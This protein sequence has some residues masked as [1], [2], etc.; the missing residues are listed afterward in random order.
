MTQAALDLLYPED[1][2]TAP[3]RVHHPT[4]RH[5]RPR[6]RPQPGQVPW[7]ATATVPARVLVAEDDTEMRRLLVDA[8]AHAGYQ[9][10]EVA[11]GRQLLAC[12]ADPHHRD[13]CPEPDLVVSDIRMPGHSGLDVLAAL[14]QHDWA[15]P[16]LIITAFGSPETHAEARRL[17]AAAVLDKPFDID[18]LIDVAEGIVPSAA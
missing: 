7:A 8:F 4:G 17:G 13:H 14:R 16:V 11:D 5:Q 10:I 2:P 15:M 12:L 18:D 3:V 6:V 1:A 9:V